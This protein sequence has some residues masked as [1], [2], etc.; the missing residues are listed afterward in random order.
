MPKGE[1]TDFYKAAKVK[2]DETPIFSWVE[3]P[4][5]ATRDAANE[6][7][8]QDSEMTNMEIPFGGSRMF[9]GGFEQVVNE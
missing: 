7:M 8:S 1:V 3:Y 9:W 5:K 4:D 2:E 6:T